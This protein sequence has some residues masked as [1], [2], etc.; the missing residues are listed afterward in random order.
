MTKAD[1]YNGLSLAKIRFE[2]DAWVAW[3]PESDM[4]TDTATPDFTDHT[5]Y[6]VNPTNR[7]PKLLPAGELRR[8]C[9]S[10]P[11]QGRHVHMPSTRLPHP[12]LT[13]FPTNRKAISS[14]MAVSIAPNRGGKERT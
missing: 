5:K 10:P 3:T 14:E 12:L 8:L 11:R 6:A 9:L 4:G 2:E 1:G 7:R 13:I